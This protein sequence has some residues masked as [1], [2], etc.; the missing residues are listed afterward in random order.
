[1]KELAKVGK[2]NAARRL[3]EE[4]AHLLEAAL[5]KVA[6]PDLPGKLRHH[7]DALDKAADEAGGDEPKARYIA[8]LLMLYL[9][10]VRRSGERPALRQSDH[11]RARGRHRDLV[12][13]LQP[14]QKSGQADAMPHRARAM[15]VIG[16]VLF[17][18]APRDDA[19]PAAFTA[20]KPANVPVEAAR[21]HWLG[22]VE[23]TG[24]CFR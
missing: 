15:E 5:A 2:A 7:F 8:L 17:E 11:A 23:G 12:G 20:L 9:Y 4:A 16:Y 1:M 22:P 14:L 3:R 19:P 18:A 24:G 21:G 10:D 13:L 6:V